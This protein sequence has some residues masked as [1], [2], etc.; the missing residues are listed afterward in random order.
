MR[1]GAE[2]SIG[3][4]HGVPRR[5]TSEVRDGLRARIMRNLA[6]QVRKCNQML[7]ACSDC[8]LWGNLR[9]FSRLP[10]PTM[11]FFMFRR[12]YRYCAATAAALLAVAIGG[13]V[14]ARNEGARAPLPAGQRGR[15]LVHRHARGRAGN[16]SSGRAPAPGER[17][18]A[19]W[20]PA[21]NPG[22]PVVLYLHGVRWNLTGHLNRM[23]QLRRFGFSVFAIDYR[24]FGKSDGELPSEATVYE[25]ARVGLAM[26]GRARARC[27]APVHLRP[28]AR[29]G[30]RRSTSPRKFP[31]VPR[32]RAG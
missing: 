19:W 28:F 22:A 12:S 7:R 31:A 29:R 14:R 17:I 24:G 26:A 4:V 3:L 9:A 20:W 23:S 25:D 18:H 27:V 10:F 16:L 5:C 6:R 15:G 13:C 8:R 2:R 1:R 32:V 21:D 30:G 11:P